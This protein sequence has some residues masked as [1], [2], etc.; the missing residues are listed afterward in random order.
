MILAGAG[1]AAV[2]AVGCGGPRQDANEVAGK[3][4]V[5]IL[6]ATFPPKQRLSEHTKMRI[7]VRNVGAKTIPAIAVSLLDP[8]AKTGAQAF[9]DTSS[10]AQLSSHSRPIWILDNGPFDGDT[11][12]SNT[13]E[14][15]RL[16]PRQ[17]KTF[18]WS[19][20][21]A[22]AG[23]FRILYRVS[24]GLDGKAKAVSPGT[25]RPVTGEFDT[26]I[27]PKPQQATVD[28]AGKVI[29]GG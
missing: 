1:L 13:W 17:T 28:A 7:R 9:S 12:Y 21:A 15:G 25:G 5:S 8:K 27:T 16:K 6:R 24:A 2:A 3:Y 11:A 4:P 18:K 14:L 23:Q 26:K 22:R 29:T 19:V 20:T 10:D